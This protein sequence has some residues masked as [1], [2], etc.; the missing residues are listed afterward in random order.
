MKSELLYKGFYDED[1]IDVSFVIP[2]YKRPTYLEKTITSIMNN[3]I[4]Q[5]KYEIIVV[6]NDPNEKM[7]NLIERFKHCPIKFYSNLKNYGQVGNMNQCVLLSKGKYVSFI[8]DD[9]FIL[10]N[11]A[12]NISKHL[13]KDFDCILPDY[14][15]FDKKYKLFSIKKIILNTLFLPRLIWRKKIQGINKNDYK[16][17]FHNVYG[18]PTCGAI[19][20][21]DTLINFGYFR[22]HMEAAWD[23]FNFREFNKYYSVYY[24]HKVIGARRR[25]SGMTNT[26]K[27]QEEFLFDKKTILEA[28]VSKRNFIFMDCIINKKPKYK[29]LYF[30]IKQVMRI[31]LSNLDREH[32]IGYLTYKKYINLIREEEQ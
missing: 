18:P 4:K 11:Y 15:T 23:Y 2:T 1:F 29:Y 8:H 30:R 24:L 5:F 21:R 19:F 25:E 10:S 9:D 26:V 20:K 14:F 7:E 16:K 28:E 32:E 27:V 22:D 31:Y 6:N 17:C 12:V 3:N 13:P